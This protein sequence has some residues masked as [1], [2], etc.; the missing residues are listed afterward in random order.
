MSL[1]ILAYERINLVEVTSVHASISVYK[2]L[3]SVKLRMNSVNNSIELSVDCKHMNESH[4]K[5]FIV[6]LTRL[7]GPAN[8]D[9]TTLPAKK[10]IAKNL[11]F[12]SS[13]TIPGN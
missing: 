2:I 1:D 10:E 11:Q 3:E 12:L 13:I 8:L 6:M 4:N 5:C 9:K 7:L